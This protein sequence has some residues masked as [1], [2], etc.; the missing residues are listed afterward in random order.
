MSDIATAGN[1]TSQGAT[2]N[3]AAL[4]AY[5]GGQGAINRV[6]AETAAR[7]GGRTHYLDEPEPLDPKATGQNSR[8]AEMP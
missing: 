5:L 8:D 2:Y 7:F 3:G 4:T 6:V 1:L